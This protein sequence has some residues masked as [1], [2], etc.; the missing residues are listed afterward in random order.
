M[1]KELELGLCLVSQLGKTHFLVYN[2]KNPKDLYNG[3]KVSLQQL[4]NIKIQLLVILML[5]LSKL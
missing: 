5:I 3:I 4:R 2:V 1:L